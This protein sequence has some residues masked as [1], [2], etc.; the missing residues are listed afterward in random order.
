[1]IPPSHTR[2]VLGLSLMAALGGKNEIQETKFAFSPQVL[3]PGYCASKTYRI[4]ILDPSPRGHL[5]AKSRGK[6]FHS[7]IVV[8][9]SLAVINNRLPLSTPL[10]PL[11]DTALHLD[12]S[13]SF[14]TR[15]H[16]MLHHGAPKLQA[17]FRVS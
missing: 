10:P 4:G 2:R 3:V 16:A 14:P 9:H 11:V 15:S 1:M 17:Q 8:F 5:L 12:K 7:S 6:R 13:L